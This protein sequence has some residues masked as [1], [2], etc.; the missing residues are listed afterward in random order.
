MYSAIYYA[1]QKNITFDRGYIFQCFFDGFKD[2][3]EDKLNELYS[4][5]GLAMTFKDFQH[6]QNYLLL[7]F[8]KS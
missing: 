5:L 7:S 4:S 3:A 2:M 6:I 8:Y 1:I